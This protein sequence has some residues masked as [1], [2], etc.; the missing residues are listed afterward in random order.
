M[1]PDSY[2][3]MCRCEKDELM[4]KCAN[5]LMK[6]CANVLMKKNVLMNSDSYREMC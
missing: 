6:K 5:V 4:K 1:N 3:E 2:R